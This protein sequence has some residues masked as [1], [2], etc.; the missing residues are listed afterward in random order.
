MAKSKHFYGQIQ[1]KSGQ[2]VDI[3]PAKLPEKVGVQTLRGSETLYLS[4]EIDRDVP[5]YLPAK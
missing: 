4:N 2:V 3:I 1:L 5:D